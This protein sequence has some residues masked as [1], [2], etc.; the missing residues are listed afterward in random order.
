MTIEQGWEEAGEGF[1]GGGEYPYPQPVPVTITDVQEQ[2][3]APEATSWNTVNVQQVG[4]ASNPSQLCPHAYHRYKMKTVWTIPAA[5]TVYISRVPDHLM[6][7]ALSNLFKLT[8]GQQLPDYDG[9][10][11]VY[12]LYSGTGPV[13]VSVMD[14]TYKT[15]Q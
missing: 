8:T 6:S 3:V 9:Q 13:S 11:P 2:R 1:R 5:T 7:G 15:V 4:V 12:A 10:Q 14:E